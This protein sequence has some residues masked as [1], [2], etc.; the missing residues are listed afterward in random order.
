MTTEQQK[1]YIRLHYLDRP[2]KQIAREIGRSQ[3]FV[4][5]EMNRQNLVIPDEVLKARKK[6]TQFSKGQ[7][8]VNKGK[9]QEEY[10]SQEAIERTKATRFQP[11]H[12]PHNTSHDY[13][14]SWRSHKGK[15]EYY[16]IRVS[17]GK[18]I[19][20]H[21]FLWELVYGPIPADHL[22]QFKD[23]NTRNVR[24]DNLYLTTRKKQ[25]IINKQGG[26]EVPYEMRKTIN[27]IYDLK[28]KIDEKQNNG[29]E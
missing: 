5:S 7:V 12:N 29:S 13:A 9:K 14:I 21:R 8:P 24:I 18:W 25:A 3:T 16:W 19:Q 10:M 22:V 15:V 4:R 27:L 6:S 11:G 23:G 26:H 28:S 17:K 1:V 2:I 20:L